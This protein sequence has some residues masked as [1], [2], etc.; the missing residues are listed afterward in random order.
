MALAVKQPGS[1]IAKFAYRLPASCRHLAHFRTAWE[2]TLALCGNLRTR[3]ALVGGHSLQAL[4]ENDIS[5]E[6]TGSENLRAA[7]D[8]ADAVEMSYGSRL[9]RYRIIEEASG[10][11]YFVLV[12]HHAIFDGWSM[13]VIMDTLFRA[14]E[15]KE[16]LVL[17]AYAGFIK[18]TSELDVVAANAYWRTQLEDAQRASFPPISTTGESGKC[19]TRVM[20]KSIA[21]P[22]STHS[23][24]TKAT[25]L[26]TAWAMVLARYCET[27]DICFGTTVS[28][29]HAPVSGLDRMAGPA[30]A[31]VPV[32]VR[33]DK[34]KPVSAL[35]EDVQAQ[36][37][38]MVAF[39]QFGL[40]NI[41]RVSPAAKEA[42]DFACLFILQPMQGG[43]AESAPVLQGVDTEEHGSHAALEGYFTY[44]LVVQGHIY[45]DRVDL[46]LL[47][48]A[49]K[50]GEQRL[51]ALAHHF[52]RAVE[53]LLP[54]D[55][56]SLGEVSLAG[57]WDL[58]LAAAWN[59]PEVDAMSACVHDLI[60]EQVSR[61]PDSD[62]V[63]SSEGRLTYAD[64]DRLSAALADHLI[65][66]GV[67]P[68]ML[69]P[70]CFEK[71]MWTIVAM[72]G[73]LKAGGAFVPIDPS[74]PVSRRQAL[75]EEI[76]ARVMLASPST[77]QSCDGLVERLVQVSPS[78]LTELSRRAAD[79][80]DR[81]AVWPAK[82]ANAAY[83]IFTSGS[84]GK[85][86]TIIVE[87]LGLC[88]SVV[89]HGRAYGMDDSSRVLQFSNYV[90]DVSLGEIFTTLALGGTVCVPSD[91]Q[92]LQGLPAF[93]AEMHVN[94]AMLTPSFASTI[95]PEQVPSLQVLVLGGEAPTKE[96]LKQWYGQVKVMNGYGP[97]EAI[98]YCACHTFQ[99]ADESPATIGRGSNGACWIV[100]AEDPNRLAP[101]GC[102]GELVMHGHSLARGYANDPAGTAQVFLSQVAWL[103]TPAD[104]VGRRFY[105]T[106]DLARYNPDG[107][108]EYMG[109]RDT[110]VKIRGQRVELGYIE[111]CIR[112]VPGAIDQVAVDVVR[113]AGRDTLVAF[114]GLGSP[115]AGGVEG[116]VLIPMDDELRPRLSALAEELRTVLPGY[117]VPSLF[118]PL[119][120]L[121]YNSS[122]KLDRRRLRELVLGLGAEQLAAYALAN[123]VKIEPTEE[124]E[125]RLRDVWASVLGANSEEIGKNTSFLQIGGDSIS[126][127]Q[128]VAAA[129]QHGI[130][131][132]V[133]QIF[134]DATLAS[135]AATA[136]V[137]DDGQLVSQA[138]PFSL[139][140]AE[141]REGMLAEMR[142]QC[143]LSPDEHI[144]DA[145]PCSALQEGL[146]ALA[147][148]QPGSY[149]AK[150]AYRLPDR[151]IS[152]TSAPPG[153][154]RWLFAATCARGL[155]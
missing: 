30:V 98:I 70:I 143:D 61:R 110:Q 128:L 35:L 49:D 80:V 1:Y 147:V 90:F 8:A 73:I 142:A 56:R 153:R 42:C 34:E 43:S 149:I 109:R 99:S 25:V 91:A 84:T 33:L 117:M 78:I 11:R 22:R 116:A 9:C 107:S 38:E 17:P 125:F 152:R 69:V 79:R 112:T 120:A 82:P 64:L 127:I 95:S 28:G 94:M 134:R 27:D 40:Q 123:K 62:A 77:A 36:A 92:R 96:S 12:M 71:S 72:L 14:Y 129:R 118:L 138:D 102:V 115:P 97:A 151:S 67:G 2:R 137:V 74:H 81:S 140:P 5:W 111:H 15:G 155:R 141:D 144:E 16:E 4:V 145:Y 130:G 89:G 63:V 3:I 76:G 121:P 103:P 154:G 24:I 133:A 100:D 148:K 139:L 114:I 6:T 60:T 29:R 41:S 55:N 146:M 131:L 104:H 57:E 21:F 83:A 31:T 122:M 113:P 108:I 75:V 124:A 87:H 119:D 37:S 20:T 106:G 51:E 59:G 85:P 58:Q 88:T 65:E 18:Y 105:R 135:M 19:E 53:Q 13:Q 93:M 50:V 32:R 47:Y 150:F 68:D 10:D 39:E 66:L 7:L 23:S 132:T 44:P 54:Q 26:R 48:H 46:V 126:A 86:K 45:E 52:A 101:I 136:T